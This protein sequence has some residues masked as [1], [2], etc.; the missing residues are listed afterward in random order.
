M[1]GTIYN[2]KTPIQYAKEF[3][4]Y[5]QRNHRRFIFVTNCSGSNSE[6]L[7]LKLEQMGITVTAEHILTSG[8]IAAEYIAEDEGHKRVYVI[9]SKALKKELVAKGSKIVSSKPDYVVVGFDKN[10]NYG[11]MK[12]A[13]GYILEGAKFISTNQDVTITEGAAIIPHTGAIASGIESATGIKPLSMG[14]PEK[15]IIDVVIKKLGCSK[16]DCCIIG[17][18]I[19][20]DIV[21]GS[22]FGITTYL[23]MTGVTRPNLLD[24]SAIQPDRVFTNLQEVMEFDMSVETK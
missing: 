23:V 5:L 13:V 18:R 1:D 11:K 10:F 7:A 19:D 20:T 15:F 12:R 21:L 24:S 9:G 6:E 16:E 4:K 2:G 22:S 17:D 14:K 3:I 8:Q